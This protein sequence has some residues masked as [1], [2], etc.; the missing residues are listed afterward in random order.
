MIYHG[1]KFELIAQ[2]NSKTGVN[3]VITSTK[4]YVLV[5]TLSI[6]DNIKHLENIKQGLFKRT[7]SLNKYRSEITQPK[8]N[9]YLIIW[10][11]QSLGTLLDCLFFHSKME[12]VILQ[13]T[14]DKYYIICN[15]II[16]DFNALKVH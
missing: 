16:K 12:T 1:Q 8:N 3:I 2:N 5:V 4:L 11:I 13:E 10:L 7:I 6:N 14:L 9:N 15:N